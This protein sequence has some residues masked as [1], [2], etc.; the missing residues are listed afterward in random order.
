MGLYREQPEPYMYSD[1]ARNH[2]SYRWI[3][4][5]NA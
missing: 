1:K 2:N 4:K 3:K 5:T